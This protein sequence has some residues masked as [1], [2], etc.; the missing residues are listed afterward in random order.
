MFSKFCLV[1]KP[2]RGSPQLRYRGTQQP[3]RDSDSSSTASSESA[4]L[5]D[6]DP[7]TSSS[8][9]LAN[10]ESPPS[11]LS[12]GERGSEEVGC[13][14]SARK[15]TVLII[16][17]VAHS[18]VDSKLTH[19]AHIVD[20]KKFKIDFA[21]SHVKQPNGPVWDAASSGD[22]K[23]LFAALARGHS[24]EQISA[25]GTTAAIAAAG[26][27]HLDVIDL[28]AAAGAN[29]SMRTPAGRTALHAASKKGHAHVVERLL[30]LRGVDATT[31]DFI[32][33]WSALDCAAYWGHVDVVI[34]LIRHICDSGTLAYPDAKLIF[35]SA[36]Q[37][38]K[39]RHSHED[40]SKVMDLI[41]S[42]AGSRNAPLAH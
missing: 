4:K 21:V 32:D 5:L 14:T 3:S 13:S 30:K 2:A 18:A 17:P 9:Y 26:A 37:N 38:A 34:T 15:T 35:E 22:P 27:G 41:A 25:D 39:E 29:F 31:R 19:V 7:T 20:S 1:P 8:V 16:P 24:T 11:C 42:A 6:D 40:R 28:L 12:S 10:S 23:A 33:D 36:Y